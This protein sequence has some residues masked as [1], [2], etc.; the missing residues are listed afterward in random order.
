MDHIQLDLIERF[1]QIKRDPML[2][3]GLLCQTCG[4][5]RLGYVCAVRRRCKIA[6]RAAQLI[7][8][9]R[10]AVAAQHR[11]CLR[12]KAN[13]L[14]PVFLVVLI[15]QQRRD[16]RDLLCPLA[17]R[18]Q[19]EPN[20]AELH[21]QLMMER[22]VDRERGQ[23]RACG[24]DHQTALYQIRVQQIPVKR[25]L[26]LRGKLCKLSEVDRIANTVDR[27]VCRMD[28]R[29]PALR[30][31]LLAIE[32]DHRRLRMLSVFMQILRSDILPRACLAAQQIADAARIGLC[33]LPPQSF[34]STA[35]DV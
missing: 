28:K 21:Q 14:F 16:H 13:E 34:K 20:A 17:Q 9:A 24:A 11:R 35:F 4:K 25:I 15:D 7:E 23:A 19:I 8:I 29:S 30:R 12:L 3:R 31:Q 1:A 5:L 33:C 18:R 32:R 10:P 6:D 2:L 26:H 22:A 27:R